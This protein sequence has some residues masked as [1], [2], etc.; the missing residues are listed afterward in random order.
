[1]CKVY[2]YCRISTKKQNIERQVRNIQSAFPNAIIRQEAYTGTKF[3]GREELKKILDRV[4]EGDTIV[5]D[6]VSR[7][8]RNAED[9][10]KLYFELYRKGVNLV[11]LKERHIDTDAYKEALKSTGLKI[12]TDGTAESTLVSEILQAIS[13][14]MVAKASADIAK[15]FEQSEKE[16]TDLQER[17]KEGLETARRNGTKTGNGLCGTANRGKTYTSKK[18]IEAKEKIRKYSKSFGGNMGNRELMDY[19]RITEPTLLKYKKQIR[20]EM[21]LDGTI[22]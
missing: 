8:S 12:E 18:E 1:M 22:E 15:A 6:S 21:A 13:K 20:E 2:G 17:T 4:Q 10:T 19:C 11:F 16:V 7:M 3:Q 14:F 5:F 9:G